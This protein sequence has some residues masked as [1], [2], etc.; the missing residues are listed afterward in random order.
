MAGQDKSLIEKNITSLY[1]ENSHRPGSIPRLELLENMF[2][3]SPLK[4]SHPS[5]LMLGNM[6]TISLSHR[7]GH[8]KVAI[9]AILLR[10]ETITSDSSYWHDIWA[11][12][13]STLTH[14]VDLPHGIGGYHHIGAGKP[15]DLLSSSN[16][17]AIQS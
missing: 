9:T 16:F 4:V 13:H 15:S 10:N 2:Q 1:V 11:K 17:E 12:A 8:C 7:L 14:C 3:D 5:Q 6:L